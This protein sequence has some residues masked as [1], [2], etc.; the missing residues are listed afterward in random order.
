M[1]NEVKKSPIALAVLALLIEEPMHPYKMWQLIR[2][3]AKDEV[4]NVRYRA[5]LYQTIARLE[6]S[7]LIAVFETR[8]EESRPEQ[9][10]YKITQSGKGCAIE[11]MREMLEEPAREYPEL[12]VALAYLPMLEPDEVASLLGKR[13]EKLNAE[14]DR[15]KRE[16]LD[17]AGDIPR[18]FLLEME[19]LV[20]Q[21]ENE[22]E[23]VKKL[24]KD[25]Q[26]GELSWSREWLMEIA[27][28]FADEN[29]TN[30]KGETNE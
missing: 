20:C 15:L 5:S 14:R 2:E 27:V 12:P 26:D 8:Q 28:R 23:W 18:L 7:G 17:H 30:I 6:K 25:L 3:R 29:D 24:I 16:H 11:W 1:E 19:F 10:V 4:V 21:T 9:T 22:I 13:V